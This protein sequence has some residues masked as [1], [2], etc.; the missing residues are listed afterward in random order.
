[1]VN[2]R[3]VVWDNFAV[4]EFKIAYKFFMQSIMK[5][6]AN[7]FKTEIIDATKNLA[8][9]SEMFKI[10]RFK[11]DNDGSFQAFELFNYRIAYRIT[12]KQIRIL[13]MRHTSREPLQY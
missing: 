2:K 5:V 9:F 10:D 3:K 4:N 12:E 1:M 8:I 13:R 7:N 11:I 6:F